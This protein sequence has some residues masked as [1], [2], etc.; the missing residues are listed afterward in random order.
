MSEYITTLTQY[1]PKTI[2]RNDGSGSFTIHKFID[3]SGNELVARSDLANQVRNLLNV[4]LKVVVRTEQKGRW[5]NYYLDHAEPADGVQAPPRPQPPPAP[6]PPG[7]PPGVQA[8]P[9]RAGPSEKDR[10]IHRQTAAKVAAV[11]STTSNEFWAN[12]AALSHYFDT[13]EPPFDPPE[14]NKPGD[15]DRYEHTDTDLPF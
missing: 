7:S 15:Q 6:Q 12:C 4:P 13:G 1:V 11:I 3:P 2:D 10:E 14:V 8:G 9:P 5:T